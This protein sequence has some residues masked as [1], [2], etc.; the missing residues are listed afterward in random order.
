MS[1]RNISESDARLLRAVT[2]LIFA[3]AD[4]I[5]RA[6][7]ALREIEQMRA[8]VAVAMGVVES[9]GRSYSAGVPSPSGKEQES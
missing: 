1:E 6:T 8:A 2:P 9:I 3:Q 5:E 4:A 7:T